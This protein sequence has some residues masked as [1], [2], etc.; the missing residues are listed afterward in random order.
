[1]CN[2]FTEESVAY[3]ENPQGSSSFGDKFFAAQPGDIS[4]RTRITSRRVTNTNRVITTAGREVTLMHS[5]RVTA[6]RSWSG[7]RVDGLTVNGDRH[8]VLGFNLIDAIP[9]RSDLFGWVNDLDTFIKEHNRGLDETQICTENSHAAYEQSDNQLVSTTVESALG[10]EAAKESDQH[11]T[12]N[13]CAS[14]AEFFGV[15]H[16][17]SLSQLDLNLDIKQAEAGI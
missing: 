11:P 6:T 7:P 5:L 1:M 2:L 8:A 17:H 13:Q 15:I 3:V 9:T 4:A 12:H 10:D 16:S 14:G